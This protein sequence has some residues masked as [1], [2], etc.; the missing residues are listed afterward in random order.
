[1]CVCIYIY[2]II[3]DE[4][5]INTMTTIA[6]TNYYCYILRLR[7]RRDARPGRDSGRGHT[8]GLGSVAAQAREASMPVCIIHIYIYIYI[9][10]IYIYIHMYI[11]TYI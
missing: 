3:H 8:E 2:M 9:I 4:I 5:F 7:Q 10:Y 6:A 1:M 11:H